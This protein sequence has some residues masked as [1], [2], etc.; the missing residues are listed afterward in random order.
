MILPSDSQVIVLFRDQCAES[1]IL[2]NALFMETPVI[3]TASSTSAVLIRGAHLPYAGHVADS[4][5]L[6]AERRIVVIITVE[7]F[8]LERIFF[9]GI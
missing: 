4:T 7:T 1:F 5:R 6:R 3:A 8:R 9:K 2:D